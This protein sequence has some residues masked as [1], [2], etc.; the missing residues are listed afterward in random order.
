VERPTKAW[1]SRSSTT[2]RRDRARYSQDEI[3][4]T[5]AEAVRDALEEGVFS[6]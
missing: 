1:S 4:E 2:A 3:E 5:I 6:L